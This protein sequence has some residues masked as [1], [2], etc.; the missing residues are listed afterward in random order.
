MNR[1]PAPVIFLPGIMGS[2]LRDEYQV[3]PDTVW[4]V[5]KAAFKSYD[6]I[7]LHPDDL[8]F[9]VKEPARVVRDHVFSLFYGEIIE[10]L[11]FNLTPQPGA[12]VPVY[13]FAYDW[14]Q[15]LELTQTALTA[16]V[17][18]V[19]ARTC[20]LRHYFED[21][22]RVETGKVNLVGHSMGGL[23]IAGYIRRHGLSRVD[24]VVTLASPF[25]G[26]IESIAKTTVGG[27]G[28]SSSS[29][30]SRER[31]A[32]RVTPAL[33]H[34]L[35]SYERAVLPVKRDVYL[36]ENWQ[37]S[38]IGTLA[39]FIER[40]SV[41][42][43]ETDPVRR[44]AEATG[45]AEL[46]L[47]GILDQSWEHRSGLESLKLDDPKRWLAIVGVGAETRLDVKITQDPVK[48]PFFELPEP[49]NAWSAKRPSARTG[50][51]TVPYYGAECA[52]VPPEQLV[53][54]APEDFGFWELGDKLLNELGFHGAL[55]SMNVAI[56]LTVSHL[57]G[58][59]FGEVWGRCSPE[60]KIADWDPPIADL[61]R[62]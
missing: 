47:A 15:P 38:I 55:P 28:F 41:E 32:A 52:F 35:P 13:P 20:L 2:T 1:L 36:P 40:H 22:Y 43:V 30:S 12:D 46:L 21:G 19:V 45:L 31:E 4:S 27:G 62:R 53:C 54:L 26:S 51:N 49:T 44:A 7:T 25:R 3:S 24:K 18:E 29:A 61:E 33:Y 23:V 16:F 58:R 34:L 60:I 9:E 14:R 10:E 42:M 8:R 57:L 39:Q 6:R 50:D 5:G 59:R 37:R 17:E 11:R 56:R 48:G